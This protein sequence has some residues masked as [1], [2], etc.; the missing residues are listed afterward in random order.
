M[1]R[2]IFQVRWLIHK[3]WIAP[4]M[5]RALVRETES[6]NADFVARLVA[7]HLL[8]N[9]QA[10][11]LER[12]TKNAFPDAND[13]ESEQV[14]LTESTVDA[15]ENM[16][17]HRDSTIREAFSE[18]VVGDEEDK[19]ETVVLRD[20]DPAAVSGELS[21]DFSQEENTAVMTEGELEDHEETVVLRSDESEPELG[22][23]AIPTRRTKS[24]GH[25]LSSKLTK[26]TKSPPKSP[27]KSPSKSP[28]K[29]PPKSPHKPGSDRF[30]QADTVEDKGQGGETVVHTRPGLSKDTSGRLAAVKRR[31]RDYEILSKVNQGSM[32]AIFRARHSKFG[33]LVALKTILG[34]NPNS[35]EISRFEREAKVLSQ[36]EHPNIVRVLDFGH[37]Q[38]TAFIVMELIEGIDLNTRVS[39]GLRNNHELPTLDWIVAKF[40]DIAGALSYCHS[41]GIVH[42]DIK[43]A[44]ILIADELERPVLIDFGL[45][46]RKKEEAVDGQSMEG[47]T[48]YRTTTN[49]GR[50]RGT[51]FYMSPEQV[52]PK[53][54][55]GTLSTASDVWCFGA[56]LYF[57][58]TGQPPFPGASVVAIFE[59]IL[60]KEP[61]KP[62]LLAPKV[63]PWLDELIL[64]CLSKDSKT[65]PSA[66]E[67][68]EFLQQAPVGQ[69]AQPARTVSSKGLLATSVLANIVLLALMLL[70]AA[71]PQAPVLKSLDCPQWVR[72]QQVT[73][74]GQTQPET[75]VIVGDQSVQSAID[76]R[77]EMTVPLNA[78]RNELT[79]ELRHR[80]GPS[81][82]QLIIVHQDLQPPRIRF[83]DPIINGVLMLSSNVLEGQ[84][85]DSY[86]LEILIG[87]QS[88]PI[89]KEGRFA[90]ALE[91][92]ESLRNWTI[93]ARD[94]AGNES[95]R[96]LKILS[97][98]AGRRTKQ[99]AERILR[100]TNAWKDAS[101][102]DI[103][104]TVAYIGRRL[105]GAFKHSKTRSYACGK[106][107]FRIAS[108]EHK[109]TGI[110]LQLL[111]GGEYQMGSVSSDQETEKPAH[112]VR[113][114][115]FLV[116]RFEL[117]QD[118]WDR[119]GGQDQR[120]VKDAKV[121]IHGVTWFQVR[122]WLL[123]AGDGLRLPSEAEWEYAARASSQEQYFWG[124][125]WSGDYIWNHD[126]SDDT[127]KPVTAHSEQSNAFGLVDTLGH[128]SEWCQDRWFPHYNNGPNTQQPRLMGTQ[129]EHVVRGGDYLSSKKDC[130]LAVRRG[131]RSDTYRP[132]LGF[133]VA[134]S[135]P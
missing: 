93:R 1:N 32:G 68:F 108:F 121:P 46:T 70:S 101:T 42:R 56:T 111:P 73:L 83:K 22:Q 37:E 57:T 41:Q 114:Q 9:N 10:E 131:L 14:D 13:A 109:A 133:R 60:K 59:S 36:L 78:G 72:S 40:T 80:Q 94:R 85:E 77:F 117:S 99:V 39:R 5:L 49:S 44:N 110:V 75:E 100:D 30:F 2:L 128:V 19:Q 47:F 53:G 3:K 125:D 129:P 119:V 33:H 51:P 79:I 104:N 62:S 90:I 116:G 115:P 97:P 16:L 86:P 89:S 92:S 29:S 38:D 76:G 124:Q 50:I 66:K 52:D 35:E 95:Q 7:N 31:I 71:R 81:S 106:A 98:E 69:A 132:R 45:V 63:E 112:K 96:A 23:D 135:L 48:H 123:K 21:A 103:D 107:V 91:E 130:R 102:G 34:D 84:V 134:L 17:E 88:E 25:A 67:V 87:T 55:F 118:I 4:E 58:I 15:L 54:Q 26:P 122:E 24:L 65:R 18:D 74:K 113:I 127:F 12:A 61:P 6:Q 28:T 64:S 82:Q 27:P 20:Q 105:G 43:P 8:S 11:E 126:N 120:Q